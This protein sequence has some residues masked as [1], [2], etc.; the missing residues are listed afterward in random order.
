M[1]MKKKVCIFSAQ[2]LPSNGGV[3]KY[4]HHIAKILSEQGI[5]VTIVTSDLYG[6][7][8]YEKQGNLLIY[9]L[10]CISLMNGRYPIIKYNKEFKAKAKQ[11]FSDKY[12]LLMTNTRF[13]PLSL[14]GVY[15][16]KKYAN[17]NIVIE[18]GTSHLSVQNEFGDFLERIFEHTITYF[19][20]RNCKEF[21]GVSKACNEWLQ[22]FGI[23]AKSTLYNA[24]DINEIEK[25]YQARKI[26]TR[27]KL[28]I[29]EES[30]VISFAGRI[31]KEKGIFQLV[32]A[33]KIISSEFSN[34]RLVIAGDGPMMS[35]LK[36]ECGT[37]IDLLGQV[38]FQEVVS[39][40]KDSNIFCLPSDSEGMPTSVLEAAACNNFIITTARGGA[41][42]L[43]KDESYGLIIENNNEDTILQALRKAI[44]NKSYRLKA[45]ENSHNRVKEYF[46]WNKVVDKIKNEL[47]DNEDIV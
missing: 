37:N 13:Y 21:Y 4:T 2:Y 40:L 34:V 26:S 47:L 16:G 15:C 11:I 35:S 46:T 6:A 28:N 44:P 33:F 30:I 43:I 5:D 14:F 3:E 10:P 41:K 38:S 7:P 22:H 23:N 42:E 39:L 19:V 20:K 25:S 32:R 12:D 29:P 36:E 31:L 17:R 18:H 45:A 27:E 9:R 1:K 24:I 8:L